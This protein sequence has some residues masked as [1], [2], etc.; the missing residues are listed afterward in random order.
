MTCNLATWSSCLLFLLCLVCRISGS[1]YNTI[2]WTGTD[3]DWASISD[4]TQIVGS[5]N[6]IW[7][8]TWDADNFYFAVSSPTLAQVPA[9][10]MNNY[11][12][13]FFIDTD[14][15]SVPT[16]GAG[17]T[18]GP[19]FSS[20]SI[21]LPFNGDF[22][23][24]WKAGPRQISIY[25]WDSSSNNWNEPTVDA[26]DYNSI[27][28][29]PGFVEFNISRKELGYPNNI[30][31]CGSILNVSPGS[32]TT[33]SYIPAMNNT[34]GFQS[35][36]QYYGF[37]GFPLI[38]N[39]V[40][41]SQL[42]L[43]NFVTTTINGGDWTDVTIWANNV[44]PTGNNVVAY[45]AE[46]V[47]LETNI[48]LQNLVIT[49]AGV[50]LNSDSSTISL[51]DGFVLQVDGQMK[52]SGAMQLGTGSIT[53][54]AAVIFQDV[55]L[56]GQVA[57]TTISTTSVAG[58]LQ[59]NQNAVVISPPIYLTGSTLEYSVSGPRPRGQE[60]STSSG[61]GYPSTV[62]IQGTAILDIGAISPHTTIGVARDLIIGV[63]AQATM[64]APG[65]QI[66]AP[67]MVGRNFN[68]AGT[69][70][71]SSSNQGSIYVT[72]N[73]QNDGTIQCN[74]ADGATVF[75]KN[76][77]RFNQPVISAVGGKQN[78]TY[79]DYVILDAGTGYS[80]YSWSSGQN[81]E[82]I[83]IDQVSGTGNYTVT[84]VDAHSCKAT[85]DPYPVFIF[86]PL[87]TGGSTTAPLTTGALTT[88]ALTTHEM[89]TQALTTQALTT[90]ELTT[91][92]LTTQELTTQPLTTQAL[93]TQPLTTMALT[94]MP[95][96]SP[97]TLEHRKEVKIIG[98]SVG[99]VAG[100]IIAVLV[101]VIIYLRRRKN[102]EKEEQ[103]VLLKAIF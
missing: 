54:G 67:L 46:F 85:S 50:M 29:A 25:T 33:F 26:G 39:V 81:V 6:S 19:S 45:V 48:E 49:I 60:W 80:S 7:Y 92:P 87:T 77:N 65:H 10:Q 32:S 79:P 61:A 102:K 100:A 17:T 95:Y 24:R 89:T 52:N 4:S 16:N 47:T 101:P 66:T 55:N 94:T 58:V 27:T 13:V 103:M 70:T 44:I 42:H 35:L 97:E 83:K 21:K 1:T 23:V 57:F 15:Q 82:K 20:Q 62:S 22:F 56:N 88:Q 51:T 36:I 3:Q 31:V 72:G 75:D 11:D 90:Q 8:F 59:I 41:N 18:T 5:D 63:N 96:T 91:Q 37:F 40:P 2:G 14:P 86:P 98:I 28:G 71:L 9:V 78:A 68:N 74:G 69:V 93:T 64:N 34:A 38:P 84:I 73:L 12:L 30:Q 43:N 76:S 99:A 53:G